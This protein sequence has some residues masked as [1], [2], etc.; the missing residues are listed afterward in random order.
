M[1]KFLIVTV[2]LMLISAFAFAQEN[3]FSLSKG[4]V[5]EYDELPDVCF[6]SDSGDARWNGNEVTV[7]DWERLTENQRAMFVAEGTTEIEW[8]TNTSIEYPGL[9]WL[10][11]NVRK[12]VAEFVGK[13]P[14]TKTLM[15]QFLQAF[16]ESN[17]LIVITAY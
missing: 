16:F 12:S 8:N 15:I 9:K 14:E 13:Y 3:S 4:S 1:R 7:H 10:L 6:F 17:E 5:Y 2:S 11:I